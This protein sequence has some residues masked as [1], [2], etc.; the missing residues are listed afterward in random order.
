MPR[1]QEIDPETCLNLNLTGTHIRS[2]LF[3]ISVDQAGVSPIDRE[4]PRQLASLQARLEIKGCL[5]A[6]FC[7][8]RADAQACFGVAS[9]LLGKHPLAARNEF[10]PVWIC[11]RGI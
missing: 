7:K 11:I 2:T 9:I 10:V 6:V 5:A 8:T 1:G 3:D 4:A